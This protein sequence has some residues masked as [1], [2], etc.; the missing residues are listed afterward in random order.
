MENLIFKRIKEL[1][2]HYNLGMKEFSSKCGLSHVAIFHLESG[3]TLK[4]HRSSMVRM[5][6]VFGTTVEWIL[7]GTGEMLPNGTKE[8]YGEEQN[9][10]GYWKD[11]AYQEIKS[12]NVMLEKEVERLWQMIHHFTSGEQPNFRRVMEAG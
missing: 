4:P 3:K 12:K 2:L 6:N 11:E 5:A 10:E 7:F 8:I 1:R 9:M